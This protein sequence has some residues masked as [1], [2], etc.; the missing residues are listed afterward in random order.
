MMSLWLRTYISNTALFHLRLDYCLVADVSSAWR[1]R[2]HAWESPVAF[3]VL[4]FTPP[5]VF[6]AAAYIEIMVQ[7]RARNVCSDVGGISDSPP[8]GA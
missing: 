2:S 3:L 5:P 7:R 8:R 1:R 4:K 6:S